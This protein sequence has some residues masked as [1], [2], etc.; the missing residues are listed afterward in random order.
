MH[1]NAYMWIHMHTCMYIYRHTH[2]Y[3]AHTHT[4]IYTYPTY[5]VSNTKYCSGRRDMVFSDQLAI[6]A[7][8]GLQL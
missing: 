3:I 5:Q 7:T 2:R 6:F 8:S 1:T 4:H